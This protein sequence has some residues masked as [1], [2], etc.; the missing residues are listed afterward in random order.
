MASAWSDVVADETLCIS[1]TG[2]RNSSPE[3]GG[4]PWF[5]VDCFETSFVLLASGFLSV[6]VSGECPKGMRS[7]GVGGGGPSVGAQGLDASNDLKSQTP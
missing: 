6:W 1:E 5:F 3:S 2:D 4:C 7:G